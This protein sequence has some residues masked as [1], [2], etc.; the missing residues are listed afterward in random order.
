[1]QNNQK[2]GNKDEQVLHRRRRN[3]LLV[4]SEIALCLVLGIGAVL[5]QRTL[6]QLDNSGELDDDVYVEDL[7]NTGGRQAT[8]EEGNVI[9]GGQI[10]LPV[11][12][13]TKKFRNILI[14]GVDAR[15]QVDY[16]DGGINTDVMIVASLNNETGEVKLVSILRDTVLRME[17]SNRFD[18]ANSQFYSG[19]SDV[20]SMINRNLGL[21]IS[22]YVIV[23]WYGVAV[24]VNQLGGIEM[25]IAD[26][27]Q[28]SWFNGYLTAV[29]N[30]TGLWAPQLKAPG[31]YIMSG[32]QVV[33][34]CR[35]RYGGVN[36]TGRTSN[37]REAINK[38]LEKAKKI[39][40]SGDINTVLN[41]AETGLGNVKTNLKL[42][43]IIYLATNIENYSI[44]GSRQFPV[45]YTS[46]ESVGSFIAKYGN[47]LNWPIVA[48][49]FAGEVKDL[50]DYLFGDTGYVPSEFV[51]QVSYQMYLDRTGQ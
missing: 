7:Y 24:C 2:K 6:G 38:I 44:N 42:P 21:D 50:H 29:N 8:D 43:E 36:D 33:A 10:D 17:N 41:V 46:E 40:K 25:T 39:M 20:V 49:D 18:K 45:N 26:K 11:S 22:E 12:S 3:V 28:L 31:T 4:M 1:M 19:I 34:Y 13:N 27:K 47:N 51:K 15:E 5:C 48:N 35:I 23:N 9:Q 30:S 32:T 14:L 37:Q 16:D